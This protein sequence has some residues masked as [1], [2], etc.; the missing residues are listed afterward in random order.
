FREGASFNCWRGYQAIYQVENDSIFL[1][2][3]FRCGELRSGLPIDREASRKKIIDLF[4]KQ[5]KNQR[6]FLD[7][8]SG[9]FSLPKGSLLRWDGV[10]HKT[11]DKET[12]VQIESGKVKSASEITNYEDAPDRI[13][14]KYGDNISD[15]L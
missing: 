3:I 10:F 2:E 13:N 8:Y 9:E 1:K 7:W 15:I 11:F 14:R 5:I 12:L 6:V 4:G